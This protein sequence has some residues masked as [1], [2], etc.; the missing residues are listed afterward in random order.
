[1]SKPPEANKAPASASQSHAV[2]SKGMAAR[3][4]Y[5]VTSARDPLSFSTFRFDEIPPH[6]SPQREM[7]TKLIRC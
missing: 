2:S 7:T 6:H 4:R 5:E 1:M 3:L